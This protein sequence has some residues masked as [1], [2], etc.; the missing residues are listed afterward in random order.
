MDVELI[1]I[2]EF[3]AGYPPF[4]QLTDECLDRLPREL[5]VRYLRRGTPFPPTDATAPCLYIVRTGA[6]EL[7]NRKDELV[8]KFGEG[9]LYA[10]ACTE[11]DPQRQLAGMTVEDS[12]FYLLPCARLQALRTQHSALDAWFTQSLSRRLRRAVET[13]QDTP[14][15]SGNLLTVAV[16]SLLKRELVAVGPDTPIQEAARVMTAQRVSALLIMEQHRLVG[17]LTDRDLRSRCLA[18]GLPADRPVSELMTRALHKIATD[19]PAFEALLTMTRLDIRHLPVMD[20]NRVVGMISTTDLIHY[21]STSALYL[22]GAVRRCDSVEALAQV[23]RELPELQVQLVAAGATA[24]QLGQAIS[25]VTDAITRRLLELAT[26]HLGPAPVPYAWVAG[27]S[28]GRREQ[29]ALSDQDNALVLDDACV[30]ERDGAYFEQLARFVNDGL[31]ACG[32]R[33]CPGEIMASN[34]RWRQPLQAWRRTFRDWIAHAD[35]KSAMLAVNFLDLRVIHGEERLLAQ[36]QAD[37]L[38]RIR[39]DKVFL[40]YLA[41]NAV[42]TRPPLGFF[43]NFALISDGEHANTFDIKLRGILPALNLARLYALTAGLPEINTVE[44]LH[45]AVEAHALSA[46]GAAN[47]EDAFEFIS[48]LRCRHQVMQF[49]RGESP[50]NY[51]PPDALTPL[52]RSHLKDAFAA[53]ST[54][55]E[56]LAQ[57][58]QTGR[59]Y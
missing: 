30:P 45:A 8:A 52:E 38:P 16:G 11:H 12:L 9:D 32:Y 28:Q 27:G 51:L 41:A 36:L 6:V 37:I 18:E 20:H 46:E 5:T 54:L 17:I 19:T 29:T 13:L 10:A 43:R 33:L 59:L 26:G 34:P 23:S 40:A 24:H 44:R 50:D 56:A 22:V 4:A 31:A 49:K 1:E 48:A 35:R 39:D 42:S 47:L 3:L 57:R 53:I 25:A 55:Q 15:G 2:R 7:R 21:Q 58:Y 14:H